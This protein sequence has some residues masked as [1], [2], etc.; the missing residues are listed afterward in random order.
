MNPEGIAPG[1]VASI[2]WVILFA[3]RR[4]AFAG[5]LKA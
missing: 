5:I 2:L 4:A 1:L 3:Q